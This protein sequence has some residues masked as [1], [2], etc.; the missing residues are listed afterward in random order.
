[1]KKVTMFFDLELFAE[2]SDTILVKDLARL[3]VVSL[4]K[5]T[6]LQAQISEMAIADSFIY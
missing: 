6:T 1:M 3:R 5:K 4:D 2:I